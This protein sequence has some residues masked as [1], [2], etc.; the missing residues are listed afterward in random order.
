MDCRTLR[1]SIHGTQR[2]NPTYFGNLLILV[3]ASMTQEISGWHILDELSVK[4]LHGPS[5]IIS[6]YFGAPSELH[7]AAPALWF[8]T[9]YLLN[10]PSSSAAL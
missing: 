6:Y 4:L 3:R 7:P 1:T 5:R 8:M 10:L 9:E 2:I